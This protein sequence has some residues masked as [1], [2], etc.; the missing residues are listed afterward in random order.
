VLVGPKVRYLSNFSATPHFGE[1]PESAHPRRCGMLRRRPLRHPLAQSPAWRRLWDQRLQRHP[2]RI[3]QVARIAITVSPINL[4][5]LSVHITVSLLTANHA[6]QHPRNRLLGQAVSFS[7]V[8]SIC[9]E[10]E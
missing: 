2:L 7:S 1:C 4:T 5:V 10:F 9:I 8:A 6:I 3:P